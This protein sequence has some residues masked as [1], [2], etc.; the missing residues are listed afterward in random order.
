MGGPKRHHYVPRFYLERFVR[1]HEGSRRGFWVYDKDG[2]EPRL[3]QPPTTAVEQFFY[4][5][6]AEGGERDDS[7]EAALSRIE[8][9]FAPMLRRWLAPGGGPRPEDVPVAAVFLALMDTRTSR[10]IEVAR[11]V[12][13]LSA[14]E[15]LKEL[16]ASPERLREYLARRKADGK[17]R[18]GPM[19][20]L[21]RRLPP[22]R[23]GPRLRL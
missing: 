18:I 16:A 1:E 21:W 7:P 11:Q 5:I 10:S 8:G 2:G 6:E 20:A 19:K 12:A 3:Q 9:E 23:S 17:R 4:R 15:S 13:T 22:L 14:I